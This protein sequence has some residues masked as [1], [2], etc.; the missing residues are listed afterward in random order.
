MKEIKEMKEMKKTKQNKKKGN[1][2]P[3]IVII[4]LI[5]M[6]IASIFLYIKNNEKKNYNNVKNNSAIEKVYVNKQFVFDDLDITVSGN[7]KIIKNVQ[8]NNKEV[9]ELPVQVKNSQQIENS[10]SIGYVT[11]YGKDGKELRETGSIFKDKSFENSPKIA[12]GE[13]TIKNIYAPYVG[14]GKYRIV[15]KTFYEEKEMEIDI[16][17]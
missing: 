2:F 1:I 14:D 13:M 12:K 8:D 5:M 10:F 16:K 15:F 17:K 11:I 4:I 9:I 6:V 3:I 7:Y